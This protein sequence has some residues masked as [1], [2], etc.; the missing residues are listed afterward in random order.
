EYSSYDLAV[1]RVYTVAGAALSALITGF[2]IA[3]VRR[4][5]SFVELCLVA[6]I[7]GYAIYFVAAAGPKELILASN[8]P[9][10]QILLAL[11][12]APVGGFL[13]LLTVGAS[14]CFLLFGGGKFDPGFHYETG[15]AIRYLK[16]NR[17]D[18]FV[19]V[20][21]II[22]VLGVC[23]GVMALIVVL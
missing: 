4:R 14:I 18:L 11:V 2:A 17:R 1:V 13:A 16:A 8:V 10:E 19:S 23:L 12:V 15:V 22:A 20:V 7:A 21:T 6:L 5:L 3:A 9:E